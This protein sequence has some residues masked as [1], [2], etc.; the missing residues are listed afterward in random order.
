VKLKGL[1]IFLVLVDLVLILSVL[2]VMVWNTS[3]GIGQDPTQLQIQVG[4]TCDTILK[5]GAGALFGLIG[6]QASKS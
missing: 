5:M 6:G 1:F 3:H 2:F 4:D